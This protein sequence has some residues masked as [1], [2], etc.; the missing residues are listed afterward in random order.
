MSRAK[1]FVGIERRKNTSITATITDAPPIVEYRSVRRIEFILDKIKIFRKNEKS[2]CEVYTTT[3]HSFS[4]NPL[5]SETCLHI[6]HLGKLYY[7]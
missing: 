1:S 6:L 7:S 4:I 2:S 5:E 3:L